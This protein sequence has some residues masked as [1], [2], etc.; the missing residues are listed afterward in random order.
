[1]KYNQIYFI[2][3]FLSIKIILSDFF[4]IKKINVKL[5]SIYRNHRTLDNKEEDSFLEKAYGNI[6]HLFYYYATLYLGPNKIPQIHILGTGREIT[7][8]SCEKCTS[9]GKHLNK[10]YGL[11][12]DSAIIKCI[13][14]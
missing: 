9:C 3:T 14:K 2:Y 7:T 8:S 13:T 6:H 5:N 4:R 11:F 10:P 1:M 12:N